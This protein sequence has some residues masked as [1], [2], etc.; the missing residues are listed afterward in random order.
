MKN[1]PEIGK[2]NQKQKLKNNIQAIR[3]LKDLQA[4]VRLATPA[5]QAVLA[6]YAGW[7]GIPHVFKYGLREGDEWYPEQKE[8]KSLLTPEEYRAAENSTMNAH[9]TSPMVVQAM[10]RAMEHL[11]FKGGR[12]L[13][14]GCGIGYFFGFMP[15][16]IAVKSR[17]TGIDLEP[18][19][20]SIAKQLFQKADIRNQGYEQSK[21]ANDFYDIAISN[22]PFAN[23]TISSDKEFAK[24]H[25]QLHNYYF[26]K[27]MQKVRPGGIIMFIT[28]SGTMRAG[29]DAAM[30]RKMLTKE[31]DLIGAVE[32]P[33][34]T[35]KETALT[36]VT[37]DLIILRKRLPGEPPSGE[38][39][40]EIVDSPVDDGYGRPFPE[41][42]YFR[43][44][45]EMRLGELV[46]DKLHKDR[47]GVMY[48]GDN[49]T[50]DLQNALGKLPVNIYNERPTRV[51]EAPRDLMPAPE[52]VQ[53]GTLI[54]KDG[55]LFKIAN[56]KLEPVLV[57]PAQFT[58]IKSLLGIRNAT[59]QLLQDQLNP[60]A[61]DQSLEKQRTEL[62]KLYDAHVKK[63]GALTA[64]K[65]NQIIDIDPDWPLLAAL[66][67]HN[68]ETGQYEK[69]AIFTTRTLKP[70]T[71]ATGAENAH[72]ALMI[73]L[74]E[75]GRIDWDRMAELTGKT[76]EVLQN[77][78][79]LKDILYINPSGNQWETSD[80]Y[81][82][83]NV[84]EKLVQAE[85]AVLTDPAFQKN[86]DALKAIQPKDLAPDE[87]DT[88][89]GAP[90]IPTDDIEDFIKDLLRQPYAGIR[91]QHAVNSA[92]WRLDYNKHSSIA[93]SVANYSTWG[94]N[95]V[96]ALELIEL[97]LA[98]KTPEVRWVDD[99]GKSHVDVNATVAA[100]SKQNEIKDE[101]KKWL[102]K[103]TSRADRLARIYND[104]YNNTVLREYDGSHLTVPGLSADIELRPHQKN[105]IW[106]IIQGTNTLLGHEVGAGKTWTMQAA[107]MEMRRMGLVNKPMHVVMNHMLNQYVQDFRKAYP[108]AKLLVITNKDLPASTLKRGKN[109]PEQAFESKRRLHQNARKILF[110][111]IVTNDWDSVICTYNTFYKIPV[112][113][114]FQRQ[115][116]QEQID[117]IENAILELKEEQGGNRSD[118]R[119]VKQLA[120]N[121]KRLEERMRELTDALDKDAVTPFEQL[122]ID[123]IFVD[124]ADNFKNLYFM[125]KM[126]R[127]AG[128]PN[129]DAKR[130][131][132]LY[133]KV[134][135]LTNVNNGR[136]VV[137]ATG[138]PISNTM[139]EMF[140]MMRYL[141]P[142]E[143]ANRGLAA[144]DAWAANFGQAVT[145]V[146]MAP[147]GSR[148]RLNTRFAKF[149]NAPELLKLFRSF[150]DVKRQA[151]LKLDRPEL[152]GGAPRIIAAEATQELKDYLEILAVRS[153]SIAAGI[154]PRVDNMLNVTN[155]GR[156]AALDMRLIDPKLPDNPD[157]KVNQ[158]VNNVYELWKDPDNTKIKGVQLIFAN[159]GVP[160]APSD[161][162]VITEGGNGPDDNIPE[163]AENLTIYADIR[164]KL[165][166]KGIPVA[167]IVYIH[168]AK[169]DVQKQTLYDKVN[170]GKIR[171]LLGSI[172]KMGAGTNVQ[173]R[174]T[175]GHFLDPPWRP[176]DIEQAEGRYVRPGNINASVRTW[177]Y[178]TKGSFDVYMWQTIEAKAKFIAQALSG[179]ISSRTMEDVDPMVMNAG[180]AKALATGNPRVLD[181]VKIDN[182]VNML[183]AEANEFARNLWGMQNKIK[184][185]P[186]RIAVIK[187]EIEGFKNDIAS[188]KDTRG[189]KF[190]MVVVDLN[191][192]DIEYTE[193]AKAQAALLQFINHFT[194]PAGKI[195]RVGSVAGFKLGL[196]HPQRLMVIGTTNNYSVD[197]MIASIETTI[198][199]SPEAI[200]ENNENKFVEYKKQ[201][202]DLREEVKNPWPKQA[203]LGKALEEQ[204]KI[205]DELGITSLTSPQMV[206]PDEIERQRSGIPQVVEEMGAEVDKAIDEITPP[207]GFSV[208]FTKKPKGAAKEGQFTFDDEDVEARW[209]ASQGLKPEAISEK[210]K[211]WWQ[212]FKNK[213]TREFEHLPKTA[214]FAELRE[215]LRQLSHQKDVQG[216][217]TLRLQQ[218][219]VVSMSPE[220]YDLFTRKVILDDLQHEL[221][222]G[223]ELPFG[224]TEESLKHEKGRVDSLSSSNPTIQKAVQ[225]RKRIW[226]AVK[227]DY[228]HAMKVVG[229]NVEDRLTKEDYYR[230]Q[231]LEYARNKGIS[232]AGR[233]L[234]T[235][236]RRG[237]LKQRGGSESD[238]N[239]DYVQAEY[240]VMAQMLF[241]TEVAK[242]I[243]KVDKYYNIRKSLED[244]AKEANKKAIDKIIATEIEADRERLKREGKTDEE[245]VSATGKQLK[246]F[247]KKMAIAFSRLRGLAKDGDLWDGEKHE[248]ADVVKS[249]EGPQDEDVDE[250]SRL[251]RYLA[252]LANQGDEVD[253][254]ISARTMFKAIGD[255]R[256]FIK[257]TLG[258]KF[259][260]WRRMVPDGI[261]I[262]Q[263]R[264]G[265]HFYLANSIPEHIADQL[266][267]GTLEEIGVSKDDI[268]RVFAKGQR[269]REFAIPDEVALTLDNLK[270][271]LMDN[272]VTR[273]ARWFTRPMKI[274]FLTAPM[275]IIKY[276][277]R[278]ISGDTEAVWVGN[279]HAFK[280]VPQATHELYQVL[281]GN[282]AMTPTMRKWFERGG[283]QTTLQ[284]AE[285]GD[286]NKLKIFENIY[287]AKGTAKEL[288]MK[289]WYGYW[290]KA[291]LA[292]D[293]REAI[294]RYAYFIDESEYMSAHDGH[295][296]SFGASN[297]E[298]IMALHDWDDRAA[299][300]SNEALGAYDSI[301]ILGQNLREF[302]IPFWSWNEINFTRYPRYFRNAVQDGK[303][304]GTIGRKFVGIG[305]R[306]PF[307]AYN[308]GKF[309]LKALG[310]SAA[311][312]L[313]NSTFFAQEEKDLPADVQAKPHV[314]LG[315][316]KDG[317]VR[318]I[319]RL[320]MLSDFL[321]WFGLDTVRKDAQDYLNGYRSLK[322]ITQGMAR[323]PFNKFIQG[324]SPL[325]KTPFELLAKTS[326]Y[327]DAFKPGHIYDQ[328]EYLAR[329]SG[330]A[331]E[332]K[333]LTGKPVKNYTDILQ[334]MIMLQS[335]PG[336][337]AYYDIRDMKQQYMKKVLDKNSGGITSDSDK[338]EALYNV[339]MAVRYRDMQAFDRYL[340]AYGL[341]GGTEKGL[342]Q[343]LDS[344]HPLFGLKGWN[345]KVKEGDTD[346]ALQFYESLSPEDREK[347]RT[348]VK[349]Y[350]AVL[351]RRGD[352]EII[353]HYSQ[354]VERINQ[355]LEKKNGE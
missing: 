29:R 157:S 274:F 315:R 1:D 280:K 155:D 80:S 237:F 93:T 61:P 4:S 354:V 268:Q 126:S 132:D 322:E 144:F 8:L 230:H 186:D 327:P 325:I 233:K 278:N 116:I 206:E 34:I 275:K 347:T 305:L 16:D 353:T 123:Q 97:A 154:D 38:D 306:S 107:A 310:F 301:S 235:P 74:N 320:G 198:Q 259:M 90:W 192:K 13:E 222:S 72:E 217:K 122:G 43:R 173:E 255:R 162:E 276:N 151:E 279:P 202:A 293:F 342:N 265:S 236:T 53:D 115:F 339:K 248:F 345:G 35:H 332:Y 167:E 103:D 138:T 287:K 112:S 212:E 355:E 295:P 78:P 14:P 321:E 311:L 60:E 307:I 224:F 25:Y 109:E 304:T 153:D 108:T 333:I 184:F 133:M 10:W 216:D 264:E 296:R 189:D 341:A 271:A 241:D 331:D 329:Q 40:Q 63:Y 197:P 234:E 269:F 335:D 328:R 286:I 227:N 228:I 147:D 92:L 177:R 221:E 17:L 165:I 170:A 350:E 348:A 324:V 185:M 3:L 166:K 104:T 313:Y 225:N 261:S 277:L 89:L 95:K 46:P 69:A 207:I 148:Y 346:E 272:V 36:E 64:P 187:S 48:K 330:L 91:V 252:E 59:R 156:K 11:G 283:M 270:P 309:I 52:G 242:V 142:S 164:Q 220:E 163:S 243:A 246:G 100:R 208:K 82:S 211:T 267:T 191:K 49:L 312:Y 118:T 175:D 41:N 214:Q 101:F 319:D 289:I 200:L 247:Q 263:P 75:R 45:P 210:L 113:A 71:Y 318:Y 352:E 22:V 337:A 285:V 42:E 105:G 85:L 140:T 199:R 250:S 181:K 51:L 190:R 106:R 98:Q 24:Y 139:A 150:S 336:E 19:T 111:K 57:S 183:Q 7:G 79:L 88:G 254:V 193:R 125:T 120:A 2:G 260:T 262:W 302:L 70:V 143:L 240:E 299:K 20:S 292:T 213:A 73:S 195:Y 176:R 343:S 290:Q 257:E 23:V 26:A 281:I 47:A 180:I 168:D 130:S 203:E 169:N 239:T 218:G 249:L 326:F 110:N 127:I 226:E 67:N 96:A 86:V 12:I 6:K 65:M 282:R 179:D 55:K 334:N 50:K 204:R 146:E 137:F 44:H 231:I 196:E 158:M 135:Y 349:F 172:G 37:T 344:M 94:T 298:E 223:H 129:S 21:L 229:F 245:P 77:D 288:P 119:L 291:R 205:N 141:V 188:R 182:D 121:R 273:A 338:S 28:G 314:I 316:G 134:R 251:F 58:R 256:A 56:E 5:E 31:A 87:I 84:R 76:T 219:L 81:L 194:V 174:V 351:R 160:R 161:K 128:L 258:D 83:G 18:I 145:G 136:G 201:L 215:S 294:L 323:S 102:W 266:L 30:L 27:T 317:K 54:L 284:V 340:M 159:L 33:S 124:E 114:G 171:V 238:I 303:V 253:G 32:L 300:L 178:V 152:E 209:K 39:W 308:I 66:E 117:E 99:E 149:I 232:G 131:M 62:N 15:D 244:Q 9:Y 68:K 297:R